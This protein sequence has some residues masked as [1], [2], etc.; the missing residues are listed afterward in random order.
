M[1]I[2]LASAALNQTPLDWRGNA[3]RIVQAMDEARAAAVSVLCLPELSICGYGCE[4]MFLSDGLRQTSMDV[5]FEILPKTNQIFVALGLPVAV[6]GKVYNGVAIANDGVLLGFVL[7]QHLAN[8]GLHYE[9]RWFSAW[10]A[11]KSTVVSIQGVE[12]PV[13]DI[14][15]ASEGVNIGVEICE[16]A[17]VNERP[18]ESLQAQ[19]ANII[20][21]ASASH[22]AFSKFQERKK[23]VQAGSGEN[24]CY[25]YANLMGNE[26]G[27][28]IYDGGSLIAHNGALL[29]AGKRFSF[30]EVTLTHAVVDIAP[31]SVANGRSQIVQFSLKKISPHNATPS[32]Q[33]PVDWEQGE[34]VKEEEFMRAVAL[35]LF[36]YG[37]KSKSKGFV[38][39]LS[40]GADSAAVSVLVYAMVTLGI[41]ELGFEAFCSAFGV[42][43]EVVQKKDVSLLRKHLLTCVYQATIN[44]SQITKDAARQVANAVSGTFFEFDVQGLVE[45]YSFLVSS[46]LQTPLTWEAHDVAL[47]NIQAR[48]RAPG[49]WMIANIKNALLL[50]TGNRSEAAVGYATMDGDTCGGLSPI[51]GI[52]KYYLLQWLSWM[53]SSGGSGVGPIQTLS[54]ITAQAPTAELRPVNFQ[55]SDEGDLMP[56]IVLD[57]IERYAIRDKM[58]PKQILLKILEE[59]PDYPSTSIPL[60]IKK[61]YTLWCQNQWKR[62]RL[63]PSFHLDDESL[64]PRTW[65]RFPILSGGFERELSEI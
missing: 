63:A 14:L 49:V 12:Y 24:I 37:R 50:A 40:G 31:K 41:E 35:G 39:S 54:V 62:E 17:W 4:D 30:Q 42:S 64:D 52:D 59:F 27:R 55:Q 58:M 13:G 5:L 45:K 11:G 26:A 51:A 33:V 9:P 44:S 57:R 18:C 6:E 61:F 3:R 47:Q 34:S 23:I 65:C 36:D 46:S 28:S 19:G 21:N 20:L 29:V 1:K 15:F 10:P 22:F 53:E 56:Y 2:S 32:A 16:D 38:V 48:V 60:W 25:L 8:E 43:K 7:K